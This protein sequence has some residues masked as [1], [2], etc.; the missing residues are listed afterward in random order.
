M[1]CSVDN[2]ICHKVTRNKIL[3]TPQ[4]NDKRMTQK[5]LPPI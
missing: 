2:V 3:L 5:E 4:N 1:A